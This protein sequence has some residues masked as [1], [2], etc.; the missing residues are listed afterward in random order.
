M[1]KPD[2]KDGDANRL[3][4]VIRQYW[5]YDGF[6]PLQREAMESALADR[7][8]VVVLPTGGGK[9]LCFQ[10][11]AMCRPGL[12]LVVSPLISLMKD[13]VDTLR[14]NGVP[15]SYVNSTLSYHERRAV[16]DSIRSGQ[17]RIL[18][19][20]PER[21]LA[22]RTLTFLQG[23]DLSL[24]AIDEA[25]CISAWGHDFRPEYRGLS[26]L[27]DRFPAVAIHAYTATATP[28]VRTDI[29]SQLKLTDPHF[30]V[31]SFDRPNL[32]Y[33][34]QPRDQIL[35]Q[36]RGVVDRHEGESGVIYCITR[37]AVESTAQQLADLGIRAM[38]YHAGLGDTARRR[39]Q[40][41]FMEG[42]HRHDCGDRSFW[43]G[44]R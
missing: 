9:S 15:A 10:A 22:E 32:V 4:A 25:H 20:A 37:K 5:G 24:I 13:Q 14:N 21:L 12:A 42:R 36:I 8:S 35:Q 38:P 16:A 18:Y 33:K 7:D 6:L 44:H 43:N 1:V 29:A 28:S 27:R 34:I 3:R 41:A 26:V 11:P 30:L 40:D 39:S 23:L 19:I 31:G 2:T 17:T